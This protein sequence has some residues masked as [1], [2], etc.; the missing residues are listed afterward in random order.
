MRNAI[1]EVFGKEYKSIRGSNLYPASGGAIDWMYSVAG[2]PGFTLELRDQGRFGFQLPTSE[3]V[4]V[5][6]EIFAAIV[7]AIYSL[8]QGEVYGFEELGEELNR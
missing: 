2:F 3:I 7:T 6:E 1:S 8:K 4:P 5:G